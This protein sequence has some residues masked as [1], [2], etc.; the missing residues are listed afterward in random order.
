[1]LATFVIGLREGLEAALIVG[2][3]AAFLKRNG[4][5][6]DL[7]R[8]WVGVG[9]AILLCIAVGIGLEALTEG[10]PQRQ[11][12]MLE[13]VIAI[14][15]VSMV[16]A[17]IFWMRTHSRDLR[18]DLEGA[19]SG[20]L[21]RGSTYALVAMA[22]L[23]VL[24]EGF[25]TSVFLLAAVQNAANGVT[26]LLGALLGIVI[27]LG[28]GW[29]I[30]RGAMHFNM[31]KF[32]TI[33]GVFL[34]LV[35]AGLVLKTF[36]AAYE[37]SWLTIGQIPVPG[38]QNVVAKGSIADAIAG[39][40]F[41]IQSNLVLIEVA[42]YLLYAV[43]MLAVV[44]WPK[45]HQPTARTLARALGITAGV[46]VCIGVA[47]LLLAPSPHLVDATSITLSAVH[48]DTL[49]GDDSSG[50]DEQLRV[51]VVSADLDEATLTL[52][53]E[54]MTL[55]FNGHAADGDEYLLS[56][57]VPPE[58]AA[59]TDLTEAPATLSGEQIAAVRGRYPVGI[60]EADRNTDFPATYTTT[61]AT[62]VVIDTD[63]LAVLDLQRVE[64]LQASVTLPTGNSVSVGA[65][66]TNTTRMDDASRA[67]GVA[68]ADGYASDEQ[69][70]EIFGALVPLLSALMALATGAAAFTIARRSARTA[71]DNT[72]FGESAS[73]TRE[74]EAV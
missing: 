3:I 67:A 16:T 23:A 10:L 6:A 58:S 50:Q 25:E 54:S 74:K 60:T 11:Q 41:G 39:G 31:A 56:E 28:I 48:A 13:C 12:E 71:T 57:S 27:A 72:P 4:T 19:A 8:M 68:A 61:I 1:M 18:G 53:E 37:A 24:R 30:Y 63:S 33:T 70:G 5:R 62:R 32:F 51:D 9:L 20:A 73:P 14:V 55:P 35:A 21:A 2:I 52:G 65:I 45:N 47:G 64:S 59:V 69:Q 38:L 36:R 7:R 22:F 46:F 66:A 40:V 42:A 15:A 26:P 49:S 43:P 17:M 29:L 34:V 44:L